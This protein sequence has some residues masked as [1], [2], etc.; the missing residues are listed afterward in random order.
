MAYKR[1]LLSNIIAHEESRF[2]P[3]AALRAGLGYLGQAL[4]D[5]GS[6][7]AVVDMALGYGFDHLIKA[8]QDFKPDLVGVSLLLTATP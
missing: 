1:V 5:D 6:E 7:C 2:A 4:Q 8:V 3:Q